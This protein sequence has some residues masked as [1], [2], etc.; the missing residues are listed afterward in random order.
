M[1][2]ELQLD[3]GLAIQLK[4]PIHIYAANLNEFAWITCDLV[5]ETLIGE[6]AMRLLTPTPVK[7]F[8][9]SVA[10]PVSADAAGELPISQPAF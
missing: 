6:R 3:R 1:L 2:C 10:L 9:G 4:T 8:T 7:M 5:A